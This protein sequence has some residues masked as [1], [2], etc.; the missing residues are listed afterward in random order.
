MFHGART[1]SD[2]S[3]V[4]IMSYSLVKKR[5]N[6]YSSGVIDEAITNIQIG[7]I[8]YAKSVFKYGILRQT[9]GKKM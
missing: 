6:N 5:S 2:Q 1:L 9:L 8:S 3:L 4:N 7:E